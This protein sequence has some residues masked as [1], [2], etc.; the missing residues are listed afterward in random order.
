MAVE[1]DPAR[2]NVLNANW[3][4]TLSSNRLN[5]F[6]FTYS[7]ESRPRRAVESNLAADTGIGFSPSFRFGNPYFLQPNVD[8]LV[9]RSQFKNNLSWITGNHTVKVG[10]EWIHTL[11]DQIF[12]GFFTGRYLFDSVS[13]F[14][15]YASPA[16]PGGF[17]PST[18]G[19]SG[20]VYVTAP[21]SCPAGTTTTGGPLLFYLQSAGRAGLATDETGASV[22]LERGVRPVHSGPVA[23]QDR[24]DPELRLALGRADH[25]RDRRSDDDSVRGVP[26]R[27]RVPERRDDPE[28]DE[29]VAAARR[30]GLGRH[31]QTASQSCAPTSASSRPG[32][33][34]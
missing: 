4:T 21:A 27:P 5:E 13:G 34:C 11:N 7:R 2:I 28:P 8:E 14:L 17:G 20:G 30:H 9:W 19:C 18:L 1:G 12:R 15:R 10:G 22:D 23:S 26:G 24:S 6:H 33:T 25:A 29:H 3:F 32:R 16:A 31:G